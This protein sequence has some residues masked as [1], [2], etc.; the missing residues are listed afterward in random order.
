MRS[1]RAR[2]WIGLAVAGIS[3]IGCSNTSS[4]ASRGENSKSM[5]KNTSPSQKSLLGNLAKNNSST[6]LTSTG[7]TMPPAKAAPQPGAPVAVT[8]NPPAKDMTQPV[9]YTSSLPAP[10]PAMPNAIPGNFGS[11]MPQPGG[12]KQADATTTRNSMP[13]PL[14]VND[15]PVGAN[16]P[17]AA[18]TTPDMTVPP[19]PAPIPAMSPMPAPV[20]Q[21]SG[22]TAPPAPVPLPPVKARP[23]N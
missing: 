5:A 15:T 4:F 20:S 1:I 10:A 3:S 11:G 16:L 23:A 17:L 13:V 12:V 21:P 9:N 7:G 2:L 18:P 22:I 8:T 6:P 14:G 19:M